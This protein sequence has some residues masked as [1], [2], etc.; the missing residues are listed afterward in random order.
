MPV[1][2]A[3][4]VAQSLLDLNH[5]ISVVWH[6]GEPL[7][8]GITTFRRLLEPFK[9]LRQS[10]KIHHSIQTNAT[11]ISEE[12]CNLF[13]EEDFH[14]G[15]SIDGPESQNQA[16]VT[17]A[18]MPSFKQ[19]MAG[20]DLLKQ[21]HIPFGAIAVI[22]HHNR[23]ARSL[24]EFFTSLGCEV[25]NIN[26][27][28]QEGSN[29]FSNDLGANTV[30]QF[31]TELF[32]VWQSNPV[33]KIRE[34]DSALNW[35]LKLTSENPESDCYS[36]DF[37]PT[38]GANGDVVVLSPE[39]LSTD[40]AERKAFVV[41]NVLERPLAE[42]VFESQN[43]WYV[44]QFFNGVRTC[45]ETCPYFEFCGGGQA[46]N[47]YFELGDIAGTET[48]QCRNTRQFVIEAVLNSL[49]VESVRCA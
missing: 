6:G 40:I 22:N 15:I 47:K 45:S 23:D 13:V 38:V 5:H 2:V 8:C 27:E 30:R 33:I 7:A 32:A 14:V 31:W 39:F 21:H 43:A 46:S 24:Y 35:M 37:W 28:E 16:R 17:W 44:N 1:T 20:I 36:R 49:Y 3:Q 26:V 9:P 41:G 10:G 29:L 4:A 48:N 42:I 18:D 25:L 12:W 11:L 19:A 34:F